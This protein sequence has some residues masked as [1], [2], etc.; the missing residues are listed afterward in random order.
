M[1]TA[2]GVLVLIL[3]LLI[4]WKVASGLPRTR[5][6]EEG[7]EA[8]AGRIPEM[9]RDRVALPP[10][11]ERPRNLRAELLAAMDDPER[12]IALTPEA[13]AAGLIKGNGSLAYDEANILQRYQMVLY[14]CSPEQLGRLFRALPDDSRQAILVKLASMFSDKG[15]VA[16]IAAVMRELPLKDEMK[17]RE[18][19]SN[20]LGQG[21]PATDPETVARM[22]SALDS[23]DFEDFAKGLGSRIGRIGDPAERMAAVSAIFERFQNPEL[24]GPLAGILTVDLARQA[25]LSALEWVSELPPGMT[26]PA[27]R[28]LMTSLA[29]SHPQAAIQFGNELIEQGQYDRAAK[30]LEIFAANYGRHDARA[31]FDWALTLPAD[32]G[33]RHQILRDTLSSLNAGDPER[34]RQAVEATTDPALGQLL[35]RIRQV[36]AERDQAK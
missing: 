24:I 36:Q 26:G 8:S 25:P 15:D 33:T 18:Y 17:A 4:A 9:T 30:A 23:S 16:Y 32:L 5:A 27:D 13:G 12:L 11:R 21:L 19:L 28:A 20:K 22:M 3:A 31:A 7:V 2:A 10:K 34:A 14:Q 29:G 35:Q 6:G 1:K